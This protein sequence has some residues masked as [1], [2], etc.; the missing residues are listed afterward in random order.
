MTD[1]MVVLRIQYIKNADDQELHDIIW[2]IWAVPW[3]LWGTC[4]HWRVRS[5]CACMQSDQSLRYQKGK[6]SSKPG[7]MQRLVFINGRTTPRFHFHMTKHVCTCSCYRHIL[8]HLAC[9]NILRMSGECRI[10]CL[11]NTQWHLNTHFITEPQQAKRGLNI[12]S[13]RNS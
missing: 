9:C 1:I 2:T 5:A 3:K 4:S 11:S 12:Y 10:C 8:E 13:N 7:Q 6:G